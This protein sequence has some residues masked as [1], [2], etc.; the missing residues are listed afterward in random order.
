MGD[1]AL[2]HNSKLCRLLLKPILLS[3]PVFWL[4]GKLMPSR[5]IL[6][7]YLPIMIFLHAILCTEG[8]SQDH[9]SVTYPSTGTLNMVFANKKG[10]VI[11]ADSRQTYIKSGSYFG[12]F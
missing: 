5:T 8:M 2:E 10:F 3:G 1:R 11:A 4:K 9:Q 7:S 6:L 12:T